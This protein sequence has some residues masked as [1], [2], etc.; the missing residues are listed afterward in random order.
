MLVSSE[1]RPI[2]EEPFTSHMYKCA[3]VYIANQLEALASL[4]KLKKLHNF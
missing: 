3:L 1:V 2:D 4:E